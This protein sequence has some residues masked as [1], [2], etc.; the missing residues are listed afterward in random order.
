MSMLWFANLHLAEAECLHHMVLGLLDVVVD[1]G[2]KRKQAST[3]HLTK[4]QRAVA[5]NY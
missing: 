1:C 4:A 5:D 2:A 3:Q